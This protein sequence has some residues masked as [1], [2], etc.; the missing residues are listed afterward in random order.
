MPRSARRAL[1]ACLLIA[2]SAYAP[3]G[4]AA[5]ETVTADPP[6][7]V[8]QGQGNSMFLIAICKAHA[9]PTAA[10]T[11]VRCTVEGT[12]WII[13]MPPESPVSPGALIWNASDT[14]A[15]GPAAA[16]IWIGSGPAPLTV[17]ADAEAAFN[18]ETGGNQHIVSDQECATT[19]VG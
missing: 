6:Q 4:H 14:T 19:P 3:A 2:G 9:A 11:R 1:V 13:R 8:F 15:P 16:S 17:C 7:T 5:D 10:W 18:Q 12:E